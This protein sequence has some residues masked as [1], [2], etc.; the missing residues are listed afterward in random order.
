[1]VLNH[2]TQKE[3]NKT[4][5]QKGAHQ[6]YLLARNLRT[7]FGGEPHMSFWWRQEIEQSWT[8]HVV[9]FS[10]ATLST[11]PWPLYT[12]VFFL[13]TAWQFF[14]HSLDLFLCSNLPMASSSF[15]E[16]LNSSW[17]AKC[18]TIVLLQ[19]WLQTG[20]PFSAAEALS[21][22]F[23]ALLQWVYWAAYHG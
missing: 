1:M 18:L 23:A 5:V 4:F 12:R 9:Y 11:G 22:C 6:G 21:L 19:F 3:I 2:C 10:H 7:A 15:T 14:I 17:V 8:P 16:D 13:L 20:L